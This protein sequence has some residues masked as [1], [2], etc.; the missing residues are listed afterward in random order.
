MRKLPD[1]STHSGPLIVLSRVRPHPMLAGGVRS[2]GC[3]PVLPIPSR[4]VSH[5]GD[6]RPTILLTFGASVAI[7][8]PCSP[9]SVGL[10]LIAKVLSMI[11]MVLHLHICFPSSPCMMCGDDPLPPHL[12]SPGRVMTYASLGPCLP[13]CSSAVCLCVLGAHCNYM[14]FSP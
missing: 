11:S 6:S 2:D 13:L 7:L 14:D 9:P 5:K 8:A 3:C 1:M 4:L 10:R 12:F